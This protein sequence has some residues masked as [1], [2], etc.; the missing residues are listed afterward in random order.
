MDIGSG[1][2]ISLTATLDK[3]NPRGVHIGAETDISSRVDIMAHDSVHIQHVDTRSGRCHIGVG[4][5]I[6]PGVKVGDGCIVAPG[7]VVTRDVAAGC[8]VVGNP[9]RVVEKDIRTGKYG[10]R[11]DAA[12][13]EG[14]DRQPTA[15]NKRDDEARIGA[16]S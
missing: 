12:G 11:L 7:A 8:V 10:L 9:A 16:L 2:R 15:P 6:Y 14:P 13:P 4:A 3:T 1:C 5:V